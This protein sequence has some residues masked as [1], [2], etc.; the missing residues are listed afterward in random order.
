[1]NYFTKQRIQET[2]AGYLYNE[3]PRKQKKQAKQQQQQESESIQSNA[4]SIEQ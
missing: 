4:P 2:L 1:M 3:G